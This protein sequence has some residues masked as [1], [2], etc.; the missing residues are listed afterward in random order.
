M[1][2]TPRLNIA[3]IVIG[4]LL[5]LA[6]LFGLLGTVFGMI[7]AFNSLGSSGNAPPAALSQGIG[8]SLISTATGLFLC[9]IGIVILALSIYHYTKKRPASPTTIV[10]PQDQ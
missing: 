7:H 10:P 9:P 8:I 2:I 4:V 5:T 6:P 1:K 3:G